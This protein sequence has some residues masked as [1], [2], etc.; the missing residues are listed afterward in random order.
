MR[1]IRLIRLLIASVGPLLTLALCQA[2]IWARQRFKGRPRERTSVG[3]VGSTMSP[4]I[5]SM[6]AAASSGSSMS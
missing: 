3:I 5:S 6:F 1:L 4:M 2:T